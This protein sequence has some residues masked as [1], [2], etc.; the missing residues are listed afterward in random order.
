MRWS[1]LLTVAVVPSLTPCQRNRPTSAQAVQKVR[2]S[3]HWLVLATYILTFLL[4]CDYSTADP[5]AISGYR[6][7]IT[8]PVSSAWFY[9]YLIVDRP[10]E[11][12]LADLTLYMTVNSGDV[13]VY[14]K[15][16]CKPYR[17]D[18]DELFG[19][20]GAG[21]FTYTVVDECDS[22]HTNHPNGE[23]ILYYFGFLCTGA[24]PCAFSYEVVAHVIILL[25]PSVPSSSLYVPFG[26]EYYYFD[27]VPRDTS[28]LNFN[29]L[30]D[31]HSGSDVHA[32]MYL[33]VGDCADKDGDYSIS[34]ATENEALSDDS[35]I[36][37]TLTFDPAEAVGDIVGVTVYLQADCDA[38][39]CTL[40][41]AELTY[42]GQG[43][44]SPS[45]SPSP[46]PAISPTRSPSRS[47]IRTPSRTPSRS[48][49][50]F[51]PT[52]STEYGTSGIVDT[53]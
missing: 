12:P 27:F 5:V 52:E 33:K 1:W 22:A 11:Q 38:I 43:L 51:S 13:A 31:R 28:P 37:Y 6:N 26:T 35:T 24:P 34:T 10:R 36:V 45:P 15:L 53:P 8:I 9:T 23:S 47:P 19:P 17:D 48:P 32:S 16:S 25:T 4:G 46:T 40:L 50:N 14:E 7:S 20:D 18:Y 44:P 42:V 29:I 30:I 41:T 3:A 39:I 2:G 21:E 49:Y